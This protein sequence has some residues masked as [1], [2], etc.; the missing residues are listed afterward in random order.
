MGC[1]YVVLCVC[2]RLVMIVLFI[3][4]V[5]RLTINSL[6][7]LDCVIVLMSQRDRALVCD[8]WLISRLYALAF[9]GVK[10]WP[11]KYP[12]SFFQSLWLF[13]ILTFVVT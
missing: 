11:A 3:L 10:H 6:R 8:L 13:Y 1:Y 4:E 7:N 12:L 2:P 9:Q 5:P